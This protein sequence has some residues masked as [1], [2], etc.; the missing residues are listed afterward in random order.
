MPALVS[1]SFPLPINTQTHTHTPT[2]R[3]ENCPGAGGTLIGGR[4]KVILTC[5]SYCPVGLPA[6]YAASRVLLCLKESLCDQQSRP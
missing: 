4:V 3:P 5:L 1:L 6:L 2:D